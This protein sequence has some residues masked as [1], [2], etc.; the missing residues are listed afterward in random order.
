ME[1]SVLS[2]RD[3]LTLLS[4]TKVKVEEGLGFIV[5]NELRKGVGNVLARLIH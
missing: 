5:K 1:A 2:K 3:Y 4:R